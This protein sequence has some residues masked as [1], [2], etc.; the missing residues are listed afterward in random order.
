M[1]KGEIYAI[2]FGIDYLCVLYNVMLMG[3]GLI[4]MYDRYVFLNEST[5]KE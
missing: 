2:F 5:E 4:D 3:R 1:R